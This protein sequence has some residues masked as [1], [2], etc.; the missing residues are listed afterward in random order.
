MMRGEETNSLK[1]GHLILGFSNTPLSTELRP[2]VCAMKLTGLKSTPPQ[3][4][5][6]RCC[7]QQHQECP[8]ALA[9]ALLRYV[10]IQVHVFG[11][12][13]ICRVVWV[14]MLVANLDLLVW[15]RSKEEHRTTITSVHSRLPWE[16]RSSV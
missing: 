4:Q 6:H 1:L 15:N 7:P 16:R 9:A 12:T 5:Q 13:E 11:S 10:W 2:S 3:H 14:G 8:K